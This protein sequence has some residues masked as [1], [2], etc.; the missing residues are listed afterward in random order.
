MEQ[1][2][3]KKLQ[4]T[5]AQT[6]DLAAI[7]LTWQIG[8][9]VSAVCRPILGRGVWGK[10]TPAFENPDPTQIWTITL[11]TDGGTEELFK[12]YLYGVT[13]DETASVTGNRATIVLQ[14]MGE[15]ARL[16]ALK[17]S[18]YRYWKNSD[19]PHVSNVFRSTYGIANFVQKSS[20]PFL[21]FK[22]DYWDDRKA[23]YTKLEQI[24]NM[25]ISVAQILQD[26]VN[27]PA[28]IRQY[29]D[30][31]REIKVKTVFR[32]G[33][34]STDYLLFDMQKKY[35]EQWASTS[36]WDSLKKVLKYYFL[37]LVP[38][39]NGLIEIVPLM[40]WL[41]EPQITL[42]ADAILG[43]KE[44]TQSDNLLEAPDA[45]FVVVE[46]Y[47]VNNSAQNTG[48]RTANG[49]VRTA[50]M[51]VSWPP[52]KVLKEDEGGGKAVIVNIPPW[53]ADKARSHYVNKK[54]N[55]TK[56]EANEKKST[57]L[58][59]KK[60]AD[61]ANLEVGE[62]VA[63]TY[64]SMHTNEYVTL[65]VAVPWNRFEL[66]DSLGYVI[67]IPDLTTLQHGAEK[68]TLYGLVSAVT[69][70]INLSPAAATASMNLSL[71][72]IRDENTN[73]DTNMTLTEHPIY[74]F[75][76]D[77]TTAESQTSDYRTISIGSTK[78]RGTAAG[79]KRDPSFNLGPA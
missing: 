47:G 39:R 32:R 17:A 58:E 25:F 22:G 3:I 23:E 55:T 65:S 15:A 29:F 35:T 67:T 62:A 41:R 20:K 10:D 12:G 7:N 59:E 16:K 63:K 64:F 48:K 43:I 30:L 19:V 75:D 38:R 57:A 26:K 14:L 2:S 52:R 13:E 66:I 68:K 34:V 78:D 21:F 27:A 24:Q 37:D 77:Q 36:I 33:P 74:D 46:Q 18:N 6:F 60:K 5:G 50:E 1:A 31:E 76:Y 42:A 11:E 4:L 44:K 70:S 71:S 56:T 54:G 49:R 53:I 61:E 69:L 72:H 73:A 79:I 9:M 8:S 28:D 45:I 40:P 51:Y